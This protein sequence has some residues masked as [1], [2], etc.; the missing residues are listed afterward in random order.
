[1]SYL[2]L[3]RKFRPQAFAGVIGQEHVTRTLINS[4]KRNKVAHALLFSGPRGVGKTSVARIY[5]KAL[6][7]Q[8]G[9]TTEPCLECS[10]CKEIAQ[11]KSLAVLEI[12]GA[13]HNSVDNVREL[14]DTLRSLP[15]P[16][17][18]YKIYIIDEVH[19]LSLSAFNALL[20]SLEEP[21]PNTIFILATT[22]AHKMPDTVLSRCQRHDFR[23]LS[24]R[25]IHQQLRAISDREN[26]KIEDEALAMIARLADGSMRDSQ[27]LLDRVQAYA[28]GAI[29][30]AD[31]SAALGVVGRS[32]M[33]ELSRS[34]FSHDSEKALSILAE[35]FS[36]G[37]DPK[38]FLD[39]F[40]A[41][42]R[43][44]LLAKCGGEK[45]LEEAGIIGESEVELRRQVETLS[46]QDLQD[47]C[48]LAGDGADRAM[49]SYHPKYALEALLVRMATREPVAE[50]ATLLAEFK[51]IKDRPAARA[52]PA[53]T[54][55]VSELKP[56]KPP[57]ALSIDSRSSAQ[58]ELRSQEVVEAQ[59]STKE[60]ALDWRSFVEHVKLTAGPLITEFLK[61][62]SVID[63][64]V[65]VLL[66]S[67]PRN[68]AE[69]LLDRS[70]KDR[71]TDLLNQFI[72][73]SNHQ[74]CAWNLKFDLQS[75]IESE[76][77]SIVGEEKRASSMARDQTLKNIENHPALESLK[78]AFPGSTLDSSKVR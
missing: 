34:V 36:S 51:N 25:L 45:V 32:S 28:E 59:I 19:M 10:N 69:Y 40:A 60:S 65:G 67:A 20:K 47:L 7:C 27:S 71:L 2:V 55:T 11:G 9:L 18:R 56:A 64:R 16:G 24:P 30:A 1:M 22:D 46:V 53:N 62:V 57:V 48:Y 5:A 12:D 58:P 52:L 4:I 17:Y 72:A 15:A 42:W 23:A 63:F 21:P 6:C 50:L 3:A 43:D 38:L 41:H 14:I 8:E 61:R 35:I 39:D 70:N 44:L 29:S 13:S 33:F 74:P 76:A 66:G 78:K 37:I 54:A 77:K 73:T 49:R 75:S 26:I 68:A 31:A